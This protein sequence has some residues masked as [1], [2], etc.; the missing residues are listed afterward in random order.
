[1]LVTSRIRLT[2]LATACAALALTA[3]TASLHPRTTL[4]GRYFPVERVG[5][6]H[7]GMLS[8]EVRRLLGEPLEAHESDGAVEWRYFERYSPRG[9]TD[10]VVGVSTS[11]RSVLTNQA[12]VAI[13]SGVVASVQLI[14][15]SDARGDVR[16]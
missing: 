8:A 7:E 6:V 1:M 11:K 3:C 12:L 4:A 5:E 10:S 14:R 2:I 13:H 9:C 16:P 15:E